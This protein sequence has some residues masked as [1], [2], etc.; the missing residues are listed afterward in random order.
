MIRKPRVWGD[1]TGTSVARADHQGSLPKGGIMA[2]GIQFVH[3]GGA[4]RRWL[5]V[6]AGVLVATA[7]AVG[8]SQA[9]DGEVLRLHLG[10]DGT[11]FVYEPSTGPPVSQAI[12]IGKQCE[13]EVAGPLAAVTGSD[14]GPG[15]A[16]LGIGTKSGGAVG[17]PCAR[18]DATEDLTVSLV[19]VPAAASA[20]LDLEL[21]GDVDV[22]IDVLDTGMV[23]ETFRVRAGG[24]VVA[25]EGVDGSDDEPYSVSVATDDPA[26][27]VDESIGN[28][29]L[30]SDAGPDAGGRDNCRVT[31]LPTPTFDALRFVPLSGE[32]SLEGSGDFG[33]DPARDT[34]FHLTG[35][36]GTIDCGDT[37]TESDGDIVGSFTRHAN[38]D[39]STCVAKPY[40]LEV[41]ASDPA[42]EGAES[43]V[44]EFFDPLAPAQ[45][46]I[47]EATITLDQ[48]LN[49]P[50]DAVLEY[51]SDR[52]DGYDDFKQM[53]ACVA[54][55]FDTSDDPAGSLNDEAIPTG[56]EGCVIE[57]TQQWESITSWHVILAGDW[58]FR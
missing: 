14:R 55:P 35:T 29:R 4:R 20:E 44:F 43:V 23:V 39:G 49:A 15:L 40:V 48:A 9:V 30:L 52:T 47:Y 6:L 38:T 34:I 18:V 10:S 17:T 45:A 11:R 37:V 1:V 57:V 41:L 28:C 2:T 13:L 32:M 16:N 27:P 25:G 42:E 3:R 53:P 26:T 12:E 58:K 19:G 8:S 54:D 33:D 46:A 51:D 22:R 56:H 24:A 36:D 50:L 5:V 7:V 31:L 21:K